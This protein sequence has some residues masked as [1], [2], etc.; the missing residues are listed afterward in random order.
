MPNPR[1]LGKEGED[2][3]EIFLKRKKYNIIERNWRSKFGEIDLV[4]SKKREIVFVEVK[5]RGSRLYGEAAEAVDDRKKR[6]LKLLAEAYLQKM[7]L[8][9]KTAR[10][11]V[12][13][14]IWEDK[15]RPPEIEHLEN[16]LFFDA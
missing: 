16:V 4:C 2:F 7:R 3:A 11:D 1:S 14:V 9:H 6:K 15:S 8:E 5:S 10:F 13:T 12:V